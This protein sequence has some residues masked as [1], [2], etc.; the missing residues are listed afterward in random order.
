[1]RIRRLLLTVAAAS[2][3][4]GCIPA[5]PPNLPGSPATTAAG[6][7][8]PSPSAGIGLTRDQAIARARGAARAPADWG[9]LRAE[10]GWMN[11]LENPAAPSGGPYVWLVNLGWVDGPL[12]AQGS[13]VILDF[14]DGRVIRLEH[15][16]S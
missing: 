15:W 12:D 11:V 16:I 1:M 10:A 13:D 7:P 3:L 5:S 9:V 8:S 14:D 6:S 2:L 4:A